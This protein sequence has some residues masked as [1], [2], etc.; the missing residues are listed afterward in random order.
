MLD[1]LVRKI[2]LDIDVEDIAKA[3]KASKDAQIAEVGANIELL[4][5]RVESLKSL[6]T[7]QSFLD[8]LYFC[9]LFRA[10]TIMNT[11]FSYFNKSLIT[12]K[13]FFFWVSLSTCLFY[14]LSFFFFFL[15]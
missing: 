10:F 9:C 6:V 3:A 5:N 15:I 12:Y 8:I 4:T 13:F 11:M 14:L 1:G 7:K 2:A